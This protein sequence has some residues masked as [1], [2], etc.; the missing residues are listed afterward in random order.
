M[1]SSPDYDYLWQFIIT[2]IEKLHSEQSFEISTDNNPIRYWTI[3]PSHPLRKSN[4]WW[5]SQV[6]S[7]NFIIP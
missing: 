1:V 3:A 7:K 4:N 2:T 5:E 6:M